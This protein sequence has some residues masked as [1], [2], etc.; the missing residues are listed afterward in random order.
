MPKG[1]L[2][3]KT[4]LPEQGAFAGTQGKKRDYITRKDRKVRKTTRMSLGHAEKK[5]KR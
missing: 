5:L 2:S 1:K 3:E 4:G